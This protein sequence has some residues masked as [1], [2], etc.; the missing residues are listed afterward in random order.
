M[1]HQ[2]TIAE[3]KLPDH[4]WAS[5]NPIIPVS[6][7]FIFDEENSTIEHLSL[8]EEKYNTSNMF[9]GSIPFRDF[10]TTNPIIKEHKDEKGR[11]YGVSQRNELDQMVLKVIGLRS[12]NSS[13]ARL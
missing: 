8:I 3:F 6:P 9:Y 7:D 1:K 12:V 2:T 5:K 4:Y 11:K 10:V 13:F